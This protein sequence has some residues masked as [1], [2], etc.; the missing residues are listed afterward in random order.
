MDQHGFVLIGHYDPFLVAQSVVFA[1]LSAYAT[2]DLTGRV[3]NARGRVRFAW[4]AGGAVAM[5]N[6]IWSMHYIGM[7]AFRLPVA[8]KY[9]WPTV[10]LSLM[11][12]IAASGVALF[13]VSRPTMGAPAIVI[14]SLCMGAGIAAMHYIGMAAMRLPAMCSY[15]VP[16]VVLSIVLAVAISFVALW[17]TYVQRESLVSWS[18]SKAANAIILGTAILVMHYVGMAAATFRSAP[19]VPSSLKHAI[20]ISGL[21]LVSIVL[22]TLATLSLVYL[23]SIVDRR[24]SRQ[25]LELQGS[26]Q[27][28]RRI[29][30]STFDA[31]LGVRQDGSVMDWNARGEAMFGWKREE[32]IGRCIDEMIL[33]SQA[34][35]QGFPGLAALMALGETAPLADRVEATARRRDGTVFPV[36]IALSSFRWSG[37]TMFAAFVHDVTRRKT[38]EKEREEARA[39]AEAASRAKSEFLAN[40]SHEIRT[41]LNGVIG[42]TDL[43]LDTELTSEQRECLETVKF[44]ADALLD[45]INDILDFSKIEAG[46]IELDHIPFDFGECIEGTLKTLALRADEKGLELLCDVSPEVPEMVV[47]DPGRLRQIVTNLVANAIKFTSAGEVS[48]RVYAEEVASDAATLH[49]I[50]SDTGIGIAGNKLEEIFESFAQAD[51]STTRKYGG[52]GLG[53]TISKR[54]TELMGGRI[55]V[56]SELDQGSN[57][58]FT[59]RFRKADFA[60]PASGILSSGALTGVSVLIIDDNRTNRRILERLLANWGMNPTAVASGR[61]AL[62]VLAEASASQRH[63]Q[64]ILTDMHMPEMDGFD[65]VEAIQAGGG[66]PAATIMMLSSAGHRGD[67][68][69]CRELGIASYLLKPVRQTE[70]RQAI[71]QVLGAK[72]GATPPE[73]VTRDSLQK[74]HS[75]AAFLSILLAEDNEVNQRL[76]VRLIERRGHTVFAVSNG[77][78]AIS[79]LEASEYDLVLMDVQMPEVDGIE[80]TQ[81]I[82]KKEELTGRHQPI[83]AMTALVMSGDRERCLEAGMD[84]YLAKPIRAQELDDIL[85]SYGSKRNGCHSVDAAASTSPQKGELNG[86]AGAE[87]ASGEA[88]DW[89]ELL[90]RVEGDRAFLSELAEIFRSDY[91][92]QIESISDA[93]A[94]QDSQS[95]KRTSHALKGALSNL[96]AV[97]ARD[98]AA[99]LEHM[100]SKGDLTDARPALLPLQEELTRVV[101]SLD[102]LCRETVR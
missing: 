6:G 84:G 100:A 16:L 19:L 80:A 77:R 53:L 17:R 34:G 96:A 27:R 87:P 78:E 11:A 102:V 8:P 24:F 61:E 39:T 32:A 86:N 73:M 43:A 40:M 48:L 88:I 26:E 65:L 14:G 63:Y 33:W 94:R 15:S 30:E 79:A 31:F 97:R 56:E 10:L 98:M 51:T 91:P 89:D 28:Y 36:E 70:L 37:E 3:T 67:A 21:G 9:D 49:F 5:G 2:L 90:E 41:P 99:A 25:A 57:F 23:T 101:N 45:V 54:L 85:E 47:G 68:A 92:R 93:I 62:A 95:V 81:A 74:E 52:T 46:K 71:E 1:L 7:L 35:A 50:V 55:W 18:Y 12:A 20:G 58:H 42:M 66:S 75:P 29:V 69:R 83:V 72:N 4:L 44:S 60:A 82:R 59:A 22:V 76:A 64:M 13:V 38:A